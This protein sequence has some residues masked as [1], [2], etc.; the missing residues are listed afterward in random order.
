M[1]QYS[2]NTIVTNQSN[3]IAW[4]Q[5]TCDGELTFKRQN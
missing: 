2:I 4:N 3:T 1:S 5:S